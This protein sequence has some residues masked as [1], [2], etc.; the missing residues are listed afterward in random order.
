MEDECPLC[1]KNADRYVTVTSAGVACEY[2][3]CLA[4][5]VFW[6][7]GTTTWLTFSSVGDETAISERLTGGR[8]QSRIPGS[9]HRQRVDAEQLSPS[10][11]RR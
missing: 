5:R 11:A 7:V 4:C 6:C 1:K 3:L 8:L 9:F 10:C 2:Y